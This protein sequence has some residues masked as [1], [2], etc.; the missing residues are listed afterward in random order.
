MGN[1]LFAYNW[2]L[3]IITYFDKYVIKLLLFILGTEFWKVFVTVR[4]LGASIVPWEPWVWFSHIIVR[5]IFSVIG[6]EL[7]FSTS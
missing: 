7:D 5:L 6:Y 2:S 1:Y 4:K 3:V